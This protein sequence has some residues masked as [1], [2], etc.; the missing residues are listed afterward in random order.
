M[1]RHWLTESLSQVE[2]AE[3]GK[4]AQ[5]AL[6]LAP[7]LAQAHIALGVFHYY[8]SRQYESALAEFQRGLDLQPNNPEALQFLAY[9]HRR[10]GQWAR[11]LD[12]LGRSQ[13]QDP[14]NPSV[15]GNLA[16]TYCFLRKWNEAESKARHALTIDPHE[17]TSMGMSLLSSLNQNKNG[18][19]TLRLLA[20]FPSDDLLVPNGGTYAMVI[21]RRAEAFVLNRNFNAALATWETGPGATNDER[22]RLSAERLSVF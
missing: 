2:L 21:G 20:T 15:L 19:E 18:E 10:Q 6:T 11:A 1:R 13:E 4:M 12:E 17:A 5:A 7:T 16:Q 3:V 14:R 22:Q 9:V 8:G